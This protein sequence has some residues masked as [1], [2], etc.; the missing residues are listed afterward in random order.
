MRTVWTAELTD[1]FKKLVAEA[2]EFAEWRLVRPGAMV[3]ISWDEIAEE[4]G[5]SKAACKMRY[6]VLEKGIKSRAWSPRELKRLEE[7]MATQGDEPDW[8]AVSRHVGGDKPP[9]ICRMRWERMYKRGPRCVWDLERQ[10][11][12]VLMEREE[13]LEA[14][15]DVTPQAYANRVYVE[16]RRDK[17]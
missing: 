5:L 17:T 9:S 8:R 13:F 16:R 15:P 4:M 1:K 2:Y 10:R 6:T 12:F 11:D 7:V 3:R 14:H